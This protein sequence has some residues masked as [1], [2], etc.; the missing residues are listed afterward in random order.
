VLLGMLIFSERTW[1]H[2]CVTFLAPFAVLSYYLAVCRPGRGLLITLIT[3]LSL[4]LIFMATTSTSLIAHF[5]AKLAQVYGAYLWAM[6]LL[7][8]A[9]FI[10]LRRPE[11]TTLAKDEV[12]SDKQKDG[13]TF[14]RR[15]GA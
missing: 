8:A 10:I 15:V 6:C 9:L 14:L 1:K 13:A 2:H 12:L 7:A 11:P 4:A 5:D 3:L